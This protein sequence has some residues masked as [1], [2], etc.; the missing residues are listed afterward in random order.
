MKLQYSSKYDKNQFDIN[1]KCDLIN[2]DAFILDR[3][4]IL[5][6]NKKLILGMPYLYS[7]GRYNKAVRLIKV[8]TNDNFVYLTLQDLV[9]YR[10]FTVSWNLK[11]EGDYHLWSIADLPTIFTLAK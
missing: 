8:R 7:E 4:F 2:Q 6:L 11:Y 1:G 9:S 3:S 10:I 5:T